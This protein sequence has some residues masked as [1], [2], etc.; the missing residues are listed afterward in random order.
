MRTRRRLRATIV[1]SAAGLV[2]LALAIALAGCGGKGGGDGRGGAGKSG[3]SDGGSAGA[4]EI[5]LWEQMDPEER[6]ILAEHLKAFEAAHPGLRVTTA[7][8]GPD[9]LRNNFLTAAMG[10]GG[11]DVV[12]GA[13]DFVGPYS[14]A[15]TVLPLETVFEPAFFARFNPFA[16]DTLDGHVYA[17]PEQFG[18]HLA[19]VYNKALVTTPPED[20][21]QLVAIAKANTKDENGDGVPDRYGIVFNAR[22]PFWLV[23]WLG[24]FGGWVMDDAHRPTLDTPAMAK[25]L[26]F[27]R[28]LKTPHGVLPRDAD[29][30]QSDT[31]FKEG[32]AAMLVNGPWSWAAYRNAGIDVGIA[33]LPKSSETGL[34]ATPMVSYRGYS[35]SK[36]VAAEKIPHVK[37]LVE[38]LT[39][40]ET[41]MAYTTRLGALPSLAA[42][43]EDARITSDPILS[44]SMRQVRLGRKMPVV[45]EMRAIWD[46]MRPAFQNAMNG[47]ASPEAAARAMQEDAVRK[48]AEM[49]Q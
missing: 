6:G 44:Q 22:E 39:S 32:R 31:M 43:Q 15:G 4:I 23:P 13:S 10:G 38:H 27:L 16:L 42:L 45:T 29:Y 8:F 47:E 14:T 46:A 19:L 49:K 17:I 26:A 40:P 41:Q 20:T 1:R 11:P 25:A 33:P 12:Y 36:R 34:W 2:G 21:D 18:N 24:A 35:I 48:I 7:H 28:S 30:E 37:A 3:G 9:D 5:V